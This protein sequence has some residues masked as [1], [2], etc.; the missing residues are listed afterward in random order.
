VDPL[1]G[2][3]GDLFG[4]RRAFMVSIM[5]MAV[6]TVLI[7]CLPNYGA[8]GVFAPILLIL[9]RIVQGLSV[10]ASTPVH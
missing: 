1:F 3:I 4:R 10:G 5:A 7:G 9:L 8:I 2:R 6:P